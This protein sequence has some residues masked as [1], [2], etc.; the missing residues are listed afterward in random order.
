M[1]KKVSGCKYL[2]QMS[3]IPLKS[4]GVVAYMVSHLWGV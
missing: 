1:G 2:L 4:N 3:Q